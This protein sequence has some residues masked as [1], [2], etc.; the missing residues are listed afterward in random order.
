MRAIEIQEPGAPEHLHVVERETPVPGEGEVVIRNEVVGVNLADLWTRLTSEAGIVP[1]IESAGVVESR[2]DGV[3]GLAP[4]DRVV[5]L[6]YF[7]LGGYAEYTRV[8]ATHVFKVPPELPL[9]I[10][11]AVP[12]NYL[13]AYIAVVRTAQVRPGER[14][15]VHAAAGGVGLAATQLAAAAGAHVVATASPNKHAFLAAQP[16]VVAVVDY[17]RPDWDERVGKVDVVV[18]GMG[19]D[20]FRKSLGTLSY[21]GRLV[22]FGLTASIDDPSLDVEQMSVPFLPLF[23]RGLSFAGITGDAPPE[24]LAEW[25]A[26]LFA[27]VAAGDLAP[28]VAAT[29]SLEDAADAHRYL[30]ERRNIGKVLLTVS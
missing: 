30:H 19:E 3:V 4:G 22:A 8:P 12:V 21:G 28:R 16:G 9:E 7:A 20:G 14:V 15:L 18:D 24:L 11:A 29:F 25:L 10:A 27:R 6:P 1:G 17:T 2:G 23:E 26:S 13:T 5:G